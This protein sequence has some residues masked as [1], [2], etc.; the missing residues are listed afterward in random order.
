MYGMFPQMPLQ[1]IGSQYGFARKLISLRFWNSYS[2]PKQRYLELLVEIIFI[3][4]FTLL[5]PL[6]YAFKTLSDY[7]F[8][9]FPLSMYYK[10][11]ILA[12]KS[13]KL[14][15]SMYPHGSKERRDFVDDIKVVYGPSLYETVVLG[16]GSAGIIN[17]WNLH[18]NTT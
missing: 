2:W 3:N 9:P 14:L 10:K 15:K 16:K 5:L 13:H 1:Y 4:A 18:S 12:D 7:L 8:P 6:Y 17:T 11:L